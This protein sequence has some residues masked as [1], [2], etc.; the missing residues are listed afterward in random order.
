MCVCVLPHSFT[1]LT[2]T[3]TETRIEM[4]AFKDLSSGV[5]AGVSSVVVGHPFDTVKVCSG[6]VHH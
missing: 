5:V 3:C 1:K 2:L 6:A 4:E